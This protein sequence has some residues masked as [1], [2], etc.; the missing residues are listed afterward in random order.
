MYGKLTRNKY[1][2]HTQKDLS[3]FSN[4][5]CLFTIHAHSVLLL[6]YIM[7]KS[8]SQSDCVANMYSLLDV[9]VFYLL[10]TDAEDII[11][12]MYGSLWREQTD[13]S[14]V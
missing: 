13:I 7:N 12:L 8:Q 2:P 14:A 6:A 1:L 3:C 9:L 5:L 10:L 4:N 11:P